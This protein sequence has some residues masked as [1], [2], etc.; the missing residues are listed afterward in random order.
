MKKQDNMT[1]PKANNYKDTEM[2]EI[3]D[4]EFKSLFLKMINDLKEYSN[5]HLDE[6]GRQFKIWMR[7]PGT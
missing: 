4:K 3:P 2:A 1:P 7:K 6:V 5:K